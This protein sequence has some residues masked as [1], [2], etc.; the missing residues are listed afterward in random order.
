MEKRSKAFRMKRWHCYLVMMIYQARWLMWSLLILVLALISVGFIYS[1]WVGIAATGVAAFISAMAFSFVIMA[2]G[3]QSVTG[4]NMTEHSLIIRDDKLN[5]EFE[6]GDEV[7]IDKSSIFPYLI[8]PGGVIVPVEKNGKGW[9]WLPPKAFVSD[10]EFKLFLK[11]LY[12]S[13]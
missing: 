7:S 8:Y 13:S 5:V 12:A 3:F 10:E 11:D 4:V 2:Y 9:I 1:P 6:E